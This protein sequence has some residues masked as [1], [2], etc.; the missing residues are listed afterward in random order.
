MEQLAQAGLFV[1][2][3]WK[4]FVENAACLVERV[5]RVEIVAF[6]LWIQYFVTQVCLD[7]LMEEMDT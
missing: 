4:P 6:A 3:L 1:L 5:G 7:R 2:P